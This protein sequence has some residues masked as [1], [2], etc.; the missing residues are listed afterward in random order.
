MPEVKQLLKR[1]LP[2]PMLPRLRLLG[3]AFARRREFSLDRRRYRESAAP[4]ER[5]FDRLDA[6]QVEA[7]L[8][9][10]YHRV[11]KSLALPA[12]R[13]PFGAEVGA[14]LDE[15]IPRVA[16]EGRDATYITAAIS[17]REALDKW[18]LAGVID[19]IV[20]P[21]DSTAPAR[22]CD[23]P[24]SFFITRHSV[25]DFS[26]DEVDMSTV[27]EAISLA[28]HSPS[29]CNREPW[30]VRVF[31][32]K[33]SIASLLRHQNGSAGFRN[34]VPVLALVTVELGYFFGPGERNQAWIEGGIF[35]S[36]LV[37]SLHALG[38]ESCMLNL[39]V[40][41]SAADALRDAAGVPA[42]E[43]PI[44]FIAI[45]H[46]SRPHRYARSPRRALDE[47]LKAPG[48]EEVG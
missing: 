32:E 35:A 13:R 2:E 33:R 44:M 5:D 10:D 8:T 14:R 6:T 25:R 4:N 22:G 31:D 30:K 27:E 42:S 23:D 47:V 11:E 26:T 16:A 12:P 40:T 48:V 34:C 24:H 1:L 37:W 29:V 18:N 36:S 17:A 28:I 41:N 38:L 43:V 3:D 7:Q 46:G 15:L 20:A 21:I 9:R 39:S 19:D 45:G